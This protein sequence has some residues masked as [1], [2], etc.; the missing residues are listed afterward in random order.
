MSA[1]LI[2]RLVHAERSPLVTQCGSDSS[3]GTTAAATVSGCCHHHQN[4]PKA[5]IP[6]TGFKMPHVSLSKIIHPG[7]G[8]GGE[9]STFECAP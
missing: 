1:S 7:Y 5:M 6:A 3:I 2:C 4:T 8:A 9:L